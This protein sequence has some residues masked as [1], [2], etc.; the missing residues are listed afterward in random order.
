MVD[1]DFSIRFT[2]GSFIIR[3]WQAGTLIQTWQVADSTYTTGRFGYFI[4]S[5]QNV[6]FGQVFSHPIQPVATDGFDV[7]S[8]LFSLRWIGGEPPYV[9]ESSPTLGGWTTDTGHLWDRFISLPTSGNRRFYR[10]RSL[11]AELTTGP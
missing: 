2:P 5:L 7:G 6:R 3:V 8:G 11:G 10:I 4:N 9:L 1:Y